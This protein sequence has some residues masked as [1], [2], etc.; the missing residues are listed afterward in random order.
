MVKLQPLPEFHWLVLFCVYQEHTR[1]QIVAAESNMYPSQTESV[2][3]A[4][5]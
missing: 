4:D 2:K 5:L 3:N 1:C